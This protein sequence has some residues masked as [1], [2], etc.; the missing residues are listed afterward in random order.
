MV[1]LKSIIKAPAFVA[2]LVVMSACTTTQVSRSAVN[3]QSLSP[4]AQLYA[5][6]L[7]ARYASNLND[8]AARVEY[9]S[10]AF[11]ERPGDLSLGQKALAAAI[12]NGD[13]ALARSLANEVLNL[14]ATDGS[15]R[16]V[17]GANA[18]AKGKYAK[19]ITYLAYANSGI[20]V[21]IFNAMMRGWAQNGLGDTEAAV[22][23]FDSLAGG[24]YF[25]FLGSLQNAII[26]MQEGETEIAAEA[27]A[28]LD[29][30]GLAPVET[31]LAQARGFMVQGEKDKALE[32]LNIYAK[33][34]AGALT[35]PVRYYIDAIEADKTMQWKLTPAQSAS[36][37]LSEPAFRFYAAQQQ[38]EPAET[39]LRIALEL[40]PKNDKARL[41]LGT[42][43]EQ[44]DRNE[45]AFAQYGQIDQFSPYTVSARLSEAD[46]LFRDDKNDAGIKVLESIQASHPSRVTQ[47]SLG[48]AYLIME[49][50]EQALPYYDALIKDMSEDELQENTQ[51]N[52]L[53]GIC[54]ERLGRWEEAVVDFEFVLKYKP[55]DADALNYLGYTWVDKGVNLGKAFDMIEKAVELEPKSGAIIDSLGWAHYK[56][57]RYGQARINLEDAA[58]RSPTSATIIDHLGDVYWK[59]GRKKEAGYQWE[60]AVTLDPTDAELLA[61]KAKIKN[62][63]TAEAQ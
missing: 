41:F 1:K 60:R 8:A 10:K 36:R 28:T 31:V 2:A 30:A 53:R 55:D 29:E 21:E 32:K 26:N 49:D 42:V 59:L 19:S 56:L 37:A 47:S 35:G 15:A 11:A 3:G 9:F 23:T 7:S 52:Y 51:V 16:S 61:I 5:D 39:F 13:S 34:N 43:L 25:E 33:A 22:Q 46:I 63:L 50:Y 6:Y 44:V 38:Y 40:D 45:D 20:G 18:L 14:D 27:F 24:K 4:Q 17:L 48:R 58:E 54:L 57:G 12:N 62:G